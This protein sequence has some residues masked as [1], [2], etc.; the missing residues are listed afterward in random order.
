MINQAIRAS[1]KTAFSLV[2]LDAFYPTQ[3]ELEAITFSDKFEQWAARFLKRQEHFWFRTFNTVGKQVAAVVLT[4]VLALSAV[5]ISVEALREPFFEFITK[6]FE[7][8]TLITFHEND[9]PSP[10]DEFIPLKPIDPTYIPEGFEL[11][12]ETVDF[13]MNMKTYAHK[14]ETIIHYSQSFKN[15]SQ[16]YIDTE[17]AT[18]TRININEREAIFKQEYNETYLFF[19]DMHYIYEISG[20]LTKEELIKIAESIP[21]HEK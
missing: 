6:T 13:M 3:E 10:E 7:K 12:S 1:L 20:N 5:T 15:G 2:E 16:L 19:T 18:I 17:D 21:I 11:T 9:D 4:V 8:F 14:N